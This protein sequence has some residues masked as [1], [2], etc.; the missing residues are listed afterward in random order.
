MTNIQLWLDDTRP[1]PA[2]YNMRVTTAGLAIKVLETGWVS[3][4]AFDYHL[5][6]SPGNGAAVAKWCAQHAKK[7]VL[8]R[9]EWSVH[10]ND[11]MGCREIEDHMKEADE[12]W[13]EAVK[14]A[15]D[16][17]MIQ[18][19]SFTPR[20]GFEASI[21]HIG[22]KILA[23]SFF[24][25][26][27][28]TKAPNYVTMEVTAVDE[29]GGFHPI[30]ITAQRKHGKSPHEA[31]EEAKLA[32]AKAEAELQAVKIEFERYKVQASGPTEHPSGPEPFEHGESEFQREQEKTGYP[33]DC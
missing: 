29:D 31:V 2:G 18:S 14:T 8:P 21:K 15:G 9:L 5:F 3:K 17:P 7:L 33:Y 13:D 25:M 20:D 10:S 30:I 19:M 12:A 32:A 23:A 1:M 22:A 16:E 28:D 4:I 24:D 26:L 6:G 11:I 27:E